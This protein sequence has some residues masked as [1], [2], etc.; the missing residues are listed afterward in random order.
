MFEIVTTTDQ[1]KSQSTVCGGG[2]YDGMIA[3]LGGP[4]TPAFGFAFGVE[5][6]V[7]LMPE[8]AEHYA[9]K[10]E[11]FI[12]AIGA[13]ARQRATALAH[14]LR[15]AGIVV[16]VEHREVGMKAQFRRAD[17]LGAKLTLA[18]GNDELA[19]GHGKLKHMAARTETPVALDTLHAAVVAALGAE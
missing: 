12:A 1:L 9:A 11:L 8:P 10:V 7:T 14:A 15:L 13:A 17:K 2:R 6:A 19:S 16:E 3:G 18:I 4:S 5:R